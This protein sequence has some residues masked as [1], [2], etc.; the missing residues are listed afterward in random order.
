MASV[1]GKTHTITARI[2]EIR[3]GYLSRLQQILDLATYAFASSECLD[4][5]RYERFGQFMSVRLSHRAPYAR[6]TKI[7]EDWYVRNSLTDAVC[8]LNSF[9]EQCRMVCEVY[10][11]KARGKVTPQEVTAVFEGGRKSF[12]K[13]GFP[14]KL[15]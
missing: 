14:Q 15:S 2:S 6:I 13:R 1:Q 8:V 12:H 9:V 3:A 10:R 4:E 5:G 7:A 11:I